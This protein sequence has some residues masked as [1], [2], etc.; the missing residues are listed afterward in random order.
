MN[1]DNFTV[2]GLKKRINEL[3]ENITL[4]E[5][6]LEMAEKVCIELETMKLPWWL[7]TI[8]ENL[9]NWLWFRGMEGK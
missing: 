3:E 6:R 7:D 1:Y 4:T 9:N 5:V 2:R 8:T